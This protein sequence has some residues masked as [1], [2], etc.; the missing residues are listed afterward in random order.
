MLNN[1]NLLKEYTMLKFDKNKTYRMPVSFTG[2]PFNPQQISCVNDATSINFTLTTDAKCLVDYLPPSFKLLRPE[3]SISYNQFREVDYLDGGAYNLIQVAVPVSFTGRFDH[4][5]GSYPLVI[6]ENDTR[7]ILGGREESG[8][9]KLYAEIEDIH[10]F[11]NE[12]FTSASYEG[13]T[14][15]YLGLNEPQPVDEKTLAQIKSQSSSYNIF[16][17][18]YIPKI[19]APGADLSQPVLYPQGLQVDSVAAGEGTVRWTKLCHNEAA[20]RV[21]TIDQ[22]HIIAELADLPVLS[23]SAAILIKGKIF[24]R[25]FAGRV[26]K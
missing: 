14:F 25:P 11:K 18:R 22:S 10:H 17:W 23:T 7:P 13:N 4:L 1:L 26:L 24:M 12:H 9:P 20:Y 3:I 5:E 8:Q 2:V 6:W 16:G 19:G 15:L 21:S